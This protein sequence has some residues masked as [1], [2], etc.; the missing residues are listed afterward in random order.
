MGASV[1]DHL[2]FDL[3]LE[4]LYNDLLLYRLLAK[5]TK[6]Q[7]DGI[8]TAS[9]DILN[10]MLLMVAKVHRNPILGWDIA[11]NVSPSTDKKE[12]PKHYLTRKCAL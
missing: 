4:F 9:L 2:L 5:R 1:D 11:W 12:K 8:I 3:N 6:T 7:P 10:A